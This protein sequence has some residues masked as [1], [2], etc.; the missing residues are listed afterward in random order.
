M[1]KRRESATFRA[2]TR[3]IAQGFDFSGK[4]KPHRVRMR[5]NSRPA[6]APDLPP[7]PSPGSR[8]THDP[9]RARE[10][11][12]A[13]SRR[14][15]RR[16]LRGLGSERGGPD[17]V[18]EFEGL[19]WQGSVSKKLGGVGCIWVG[20]QKSEHDSLD[21]IPKLC[22][23][24][25]ALP[26]PKTR[27]QQAGVVPRDRVI[28]FDSPGGRILDQSSY[29]PTVPSSV[30]GCHR[31]VP[32]WAVDG[33]NWNIPKQEIEYECFGESF[34]GEQTR[35]TQDAPDFRFSRNRNK[36]NTPASNVQQV[37]QQDRRRL[38]RTNCITGRGRIACS[39]A[40][41]GVAPEKMARKHPGDIRRGFNQMQ[42]VYARRFFGSIARIEYSGTRPEIA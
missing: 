42:A 39:R 15:A 34:L 17:S 12:V 36:Y 35:E 8:Q 9:Q 10:Q 7:W 5:T 25:Q 4:W 40:D 19:E 24:E 27:G 33:R 26:A 21:Q 13:T 41:S 37:S 2:G 16:R 3:Y 1:S 18:W 11:W 32:R 30:K 6:P 38:V 29:P 31:K 14:L 22:G 28:S 23:K 20:E